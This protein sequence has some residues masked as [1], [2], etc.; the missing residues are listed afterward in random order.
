MEA[1]MGARVRMSED[2]AA[3]DESKP[4]STRKTRN[5]RLRVISP[6]FISKSELAIHLRCTPRSIEDWVELGRFP[7]PH[8]RPGD[9]HTIW[10]KVY[11]DEYVR[12]GRWPK[13]AYS[14]W[15]DQT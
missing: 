15:S 5:H 6:I 11:F 2:V 10:L 8:S 12:T 3:I 13:A 9:R 4:R 1:A 14:D 7:P